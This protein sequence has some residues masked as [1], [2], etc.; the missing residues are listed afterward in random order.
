MCHTGRSRIGADQDVYPVVVLPQGA[1]L[2][3]LEVTWL[4]EGV[5]DLLA[6]G[7]ALFLALVFFLFGRLLFFV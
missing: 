4:A 2:H 5:Q 6:D 7:G 3:A 1:N